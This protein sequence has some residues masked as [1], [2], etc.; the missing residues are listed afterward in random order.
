[1]TKD[2]WDETW[3]RLRDWTN[4]QAP[5]ERLAAE[6]LLFDGYEGVDPSHPL[7]GP[8]GGKDIL[9]KKDGL[10]CLAGVYFP[11]GHQ[12]FRETKKKFR[13]DLRKAEMQ[14]PPID[15]F[16]LVTNQ[17]L[18]LAEREELA[19]LAREIDVELY[20]LERITAILDFPAMKTVRSQFLV[21]DGDSSDG[22]GGRGGSGY[23]TG[24]RANV[25]GGLGG[26]CPCFRD[27]W[28]GQTQVLL[29]ST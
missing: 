13:G 5:S 16:I 11:R 23:V 22:S 14:Q 10:R 18:R 24:N 17:E 2:R 20:H 21:I 25:I 19:G 29:Y 12:N 6:I 26:Q 27:I 9:C 8:D 1:M 7:G 3:H 15:R 28:P 4:G